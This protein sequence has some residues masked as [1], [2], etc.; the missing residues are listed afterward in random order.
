MT[1]RITV[2]QTR[3]LLR[4]R[5]H[6]DDAAAASLATLTPAPAAASAVTPTDTRRF[7]SGCAARSAKTVWATAMP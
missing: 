7:R 6:P 4:T 3:R 1:P 2:A 5:P